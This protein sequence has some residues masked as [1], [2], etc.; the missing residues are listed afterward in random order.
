MITS[1]LAL[2]IHRT[3]YVVPFVF[4]SLGTIC[5]VFIAGNY[6]TCLFLRDYIVLVDVRDFIVLVDVRAQA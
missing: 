5:R 2:F 1:I 4:D 3:G 6:T